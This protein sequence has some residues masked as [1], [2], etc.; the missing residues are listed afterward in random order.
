MRRRKSL[1]RKTAFSSR[2]ELHQGTA[3]QEELNMVA[4]S[5]SDYIGQ[6]SARSEE[7]YVQQVSPMGSDTLFGVVVLVLGMIPVA[8][9]ITA[10]LTSPP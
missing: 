1:R 2:L 9:V 5:A 6:P 3:A 8:L 7:S 4:H 10:V